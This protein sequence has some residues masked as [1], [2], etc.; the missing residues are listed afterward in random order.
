MEKTENSTPYSPR[1]GEAETGGTGRLKIFFGYAAGVGKTY[2]MLEA[3]HQAQKEGV[4]VVVGYVEPHARPDTLAL[5]EGLEVLSCREVDYRGIRLRE[6]DLDG[7]LARR[8]QLILVDELAHSNAPGCR[9]TKR[10]QD[11]EELLQAGINVYT[12]VNVQHLESLNDLV[13]SITGIVVN[14]RIPDHVFDR[15]N[16]VELV[17][18]A[19]ADLEKRLEEGKIYRQRQAKQALENFFTA[20]NLTALREIAM[21]RT[22]DQLNRTAVQ[23]KKGKAARAGDHILICLS[24]APSN[25][26]VIRTAARMAEAFHS[27]FTALFVQTPETKELSGE[28]IKRLRSN[29][30]LAEQLGAQIATVYGADPAEQ[31][32][33]YARVSGITKIVMGRVNHRQHPWIGQ[34]SLADRLIERT[35]LDVYIIPDRQPLY[36]KPLGK[37]R[38]SRVRFS[39]R[40]AVVTLLCLAIST[41]VGFAFDWAGFSESNIITIY[42]LGVLVTAVSTSGHLYGA[43]NSLLSVLAFNFF[44]TEPRF[45][46]QADGPSY[47]VTFL[48]MLSSSIIASSLASRV[49][50]QARMAAEKSYYTEL[51]LGSSQ[52]L[53]T[54]R[55]E[56]DCL[57]LTAEQLSRMFD[58]P[59]IYAL[60]DADKELDFRI[61]PADEHTLLEKLSTEEIGVAKWVQKNNKHAGATTNTLPDSKWL[62][63][64]VRGT[65]GVMGIVGVPIAGYVVPD[66]F[67]KNLMVALLG[68]CG[69]SQ[70]RIRL[71]EERNQIALQTQRESLQANLLRAVS[72][73]LRTPLTNIN[74]SVGILMGKDQT[75]KPEVREQLYTAIDDDTNWLINMTENLLAATQLETDRTKLKTAPELLE[76]LFQSAVR[77]LDRRARDHHISVDLEDQTLMASMNAGMIQRVIINMMN[78]AI[79]Y[80]PKDSHI[81]LSGTR[82]KDWVE[83]SVSDDGPGIPDEAKKHLFDLFYTAEQGKPD[84]KRGLGL[85]LHLCQSIVNA[86]GGTITVSDHAP[87]GTTFRFTLPAVRTD[88]VK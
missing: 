57:R 24:S 32:A 20:E 51:L 40:D 37:L 66:A 12:T 65:R 19:P 62:F 50:E 21:R 14:E 47:P 5:L 18:I 15:A 71:E 22:A 76:D 73:D 11:V 46:L 74:G 35:D 2:A 75:L 68:E 1:Y 6:F 36:K 7:A 30:R 9:H 8:P 45:T 4:D 26:K 60:N 84:S 81:I 10:Y 80:T 79:Q 64:S 23:E 27:G 61:E 48:I 34:K 59:V 55:T 44:F 78:N 87:S 85:G 82:R 13:T 54:I 28:N 69:L 31:I 17:D 39:W 52:K 67:E 63:L 49:K 33:E 42:I 88:G 77:Q 58:R 41:A 83:I 38:K 25:A 43:A 70:E 16:Q 3:A 53:Q 56:W 29:L 72:H 86:H